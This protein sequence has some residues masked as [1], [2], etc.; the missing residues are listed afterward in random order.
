M[1]KR[2][3]NK[4]DSKELEFSLLHALG[5]IY[6]DRLMQPDAALRAFQMASERKPE[7]LQEH[8][9]LAELAAR[10]GNTTE[11]VTRWQ[12]IAQQDVGNAEALHAIYDLYY[13]SHQHD[14]AWCVAATTSFLLRDRAREDLRAFFEQYRPRKPLQPTGRLTEENWVKQLFHPNED[15]VVGKIFASILG[16]VRR[17]RSSRSS[18][19]A[20]PRRSCRT[21]RTPPSRWCA[22]SQQS[23]QALNLP[24]PSIFLK[25]QQQGGLGYVPSEPIASFAGAG[26]SPGCGP[27]SSPS[28]RRST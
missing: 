5:L 9:I 14:K 11:A 15:P 6:R 19:S 22:R 12:T 24:L 7:D 20:S 25:P 4:P 28:S 2:I 21:R 13:Q 10:M 26:C 18:S 17:A 16:A 8:K 1:L 3:I 23:S 27:R